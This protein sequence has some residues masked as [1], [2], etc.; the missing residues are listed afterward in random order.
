[1]KCN[2][3]NFDSPPEM[4]FCGQCGS[5]LRQ[6]CPECQFANPLNYRYCGLCGTS[7]TKNHIASSFPRPHVAAKP[8]GA[9]IQAPLAGERRPVTVILTDVVGST[10]L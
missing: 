1:M 9:P 6:L 4:L 10:D 3:C 8:N 5:R 2:Q 7:L